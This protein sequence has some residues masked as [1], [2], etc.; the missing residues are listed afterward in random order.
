[1]VPYNAELNIVVVGTHSKTAYGILEWVIEVRK[2]EEDV[3]Q[4][5]VRV[6]PRMELRKGNKYDGMIV[7]TR[8][9]KLEH[10]NIDTA[11]KLRKA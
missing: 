8:S 5:C 3:M 10:L 1:V 6:S 11:W 7:W 9:L 4:E 2:W